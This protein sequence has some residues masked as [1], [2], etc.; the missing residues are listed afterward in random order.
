MHYKGKNHC[1]NCGK[2]GSDKK[3]SE[4]EYKTAGENSI[5]SGVKKRKVSGCVPSSARSMDVMNPIIM[6]FITHGQGILFHFTL[7]SDNKCWNIH[8]HNPGST[9]ATSSLN[10]ILA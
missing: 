6:G 9:T 1:D 7:T 8:G 5:G 10:V 2:C 4:N 3:K